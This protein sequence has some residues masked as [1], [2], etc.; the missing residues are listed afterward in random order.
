MMYSDLISKLQVED[1]EVLEEIYDSLSE[2]L[3][4]PSTQIGYKIYTFV[5]NSNLMTC[6]CLLS[7]AYNSLM[8]CFHVTSSTNY[9]PHMSTEKSHFS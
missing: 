2:V 3:S 1:G 9:G 5:S 7:Y 6:N 4:R 8:N